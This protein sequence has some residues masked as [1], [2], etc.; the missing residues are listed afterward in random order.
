M[1]RT[2]LYILLFI[3]F[4]YLLK[5]FLRTLFSPGTRRK[6]DPEAEELVQ[7]PCCLTYIPKRTALKK[8][9]SGKEIH[10]CGKECLRNYLK[11]HQ[12]PGG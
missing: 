6:A 9:I 4:Y 7:D 2:I 1:L 10:F 5:L 3:V 12:I 11:D 8:K